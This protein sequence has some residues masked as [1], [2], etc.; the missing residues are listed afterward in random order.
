VQRTAQL[1]STYQSEMRTQGE[2]T[3]ST[4][5]STKQRL[6]QLAGT[7]L[8]DPKR[9]NEDLLAPTVQLNGDDTVGSGTLIRSTRDVK[10][11]KAI[12]YVI[13]SYHVVRN[14]LADSPGAKVD[15][16]AVTIYE[17][18]RK[19]E[20]RGRMVSHDA[21]IDAALLELE[22]DQVFKHVARV[23]P[24]DKIDSVAVWD[25]VYALGCPLGND[26]IPTTGELSSKNNVLNG[27]NYWMINAPTYYGN[28]GGGIYAADGHCLIGVFSKIY[29]HGKGNPIVVP[30]MG[31]CTP[32]TS[33]YKWLDREG[34]GEIVPQPMPMATVAAKPN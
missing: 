22:T 13:T 19:V 16:I 12:N 11:G 18:D 20:V 34:L 28:S 2:F 30:H 25:T 21:E 10:T 14:I 3:R 26:P 9:L 6:E 31:L 7:L 29:T 27:A 32:I 24:R 23:I 33:I 17:G 1:F 5:E 8:P 4:L 15:G